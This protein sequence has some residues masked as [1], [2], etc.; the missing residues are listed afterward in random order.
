MA[1]VSIGQ[2]ENLEDLVRDL[3]SVREALEAACREQIAVAEQKCAEA[4][5]EAQN[6]A[7][8]L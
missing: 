7:S 1:Q 5:E 6:S 4:R 8:M 2:V 3:Q